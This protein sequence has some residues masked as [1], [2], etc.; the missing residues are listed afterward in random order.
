MRKAPFLFLLVLIP[1]I[2]LECGAQEKSQ[3][4]MI[5]ESVVT[6]IDFSTCIQASFSAS[7]DSKRVAYVAK[8]GDKWFAVVDGKEGKQYD[9]IGD[10][11]FSPDSKLVAYVAKAGDKW[12][13]VVDGKEGKQYDSI[14]TLQGGGIVFDSSDRLHYLACKG[15][16]IYLVE[17]IIK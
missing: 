6:Q 10:P 5:S 2:L 15:N 13:A 16:S 8:A 12:F 3:A 14:L 1:S 7:P 17:E 9:R 11:K 4:R